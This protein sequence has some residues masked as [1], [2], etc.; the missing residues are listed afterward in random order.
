[1]KCEVEQP[2]TNFYRRS[3]KY[4]TLTARCKSCIRERQRVY[5]S[6]PGRQEAKLERSR[7][8]R[9]RDPERAF[10][11]QRSARLKSIYGITI[12][13]YDT[14]LAAQGGGCAICDRKDS[15]I[16]QRAGRRDCAFH[17]DHCHET[18][19]VRGLLCRACNS[20]LGN[21]MDSP[22]LCRRAAR[23]LDSSIIKVALRP[24]ASRV[25]GA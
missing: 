9:Q 7:Q 21:L 23:Y 2:L 11:S 6:A 8:W 15:G 20:A 12:D 25:L 24:D 13:Q 18:G 14:M 10:R 3:P 16:P 1:M 22:D 17:V 5:E 4:K 19:E